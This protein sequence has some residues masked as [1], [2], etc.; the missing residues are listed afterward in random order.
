MRRRGLNVEEI[1]S[2]IDSKALIVTDLAV[3][4]EH[5]RINLPAS[6]RTLDENRAI[7]ELE[8]EMQELALELLDDNIS[9]EA[10]LRYISQSLAGRSCGR[11]TILPVDLNE[12]A[13][14]VKLGHG[15]SDLRRRGR[16]Q[17]HVP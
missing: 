14:V 3:G 16:R 15:A 9:I 7:Q 8:A 1:K 4:F 10:S 2:T 13:C 12:D 11:Q 17:E 5:R 6:G